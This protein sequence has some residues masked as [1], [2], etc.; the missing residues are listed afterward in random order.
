LTKDY[1]IYLNR[2]RANIYDVGLEFLTKNLRVG[3]KDR[4][5][6]FDFPGTWQFL[7]RWAGGLWA[8]RTITRE[9]I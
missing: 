4:G 9:R 6:P 7:N 1:R 8:S 2:E 3:L 5:I